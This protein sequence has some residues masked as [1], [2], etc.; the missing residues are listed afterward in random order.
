MA[1][2]HDLAS[3]IL[4]VWFLHAVIRDA[5]IGMLP[6][7]G[8]FYLCCASGSFWAELNICVPLYT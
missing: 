6:G 1:A 4:A 8:S 2:G 7:S 5:R 3:P